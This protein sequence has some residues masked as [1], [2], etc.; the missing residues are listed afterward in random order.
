MCHQPRAATSGKDGLGKHWQAVGRKLSGSEHRE[1]AGLGRL[2]D[3]NGRFIIGRAHYQ[4][5]ELKCLE[6]DR[7]CDRL[8]PPGVIAN[9]L[10]RPHTF[11]E[12]YELARHTAGQDRECRPQLRK[13]SSRAR[14]QEF[15]ARGHV[16]RWQLDDIL[17]GAVELVPLRKSVQ[18]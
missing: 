1:Y 18:I 15:A 12:P 10:A 13:L 9:T 14:R 11:H 7:R 3:R 5:A 6:L 4:A 8:P 17:K 16:E 2:A